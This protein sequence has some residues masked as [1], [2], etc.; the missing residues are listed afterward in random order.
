MRTKPLFELSSALEITPRPEWKQR[1]ITAITEDSRRAGPGSLFV[2]IRGTRADGNAFV[3]DA[4]ARGAGAVVTEEPIPLKVPCLTVPHARD[5]LARLSATFFDH[6]TRELRTIA[7]TGTNGKTTV[8]HLIAHLLG[9]DQTA[10]IGT[11]ANTATGLP[12]VTT[13]SPPMIQ[14]LARCAVEQGKK[15][16]VIEAS[17]VG[18]EQGR[19]KEVAFG[20][21]AFTNLTSDHL[22]LHH[23]V[24][25]YYEAK[26]ILFRT[27]KPTA[28]AVV[29]LDDPAGK[30]LLVETAARTFTVGRA[31]DADLRAQDIGCAW[32]ETAFVLHHKAAEA[33]V[34][35]PLTGMHNVSNV[36]VAAGVALCEGVPLQQIA[37]RLPSFRPVAGRLETLHNDTGVT[38]VVDFAHNTDALERTLETLRQFFP[39][40]ITVFGC[41]GDAD[42]EK[43]PA[44]GAT[45]Q[46][47]SDAVVVTTDNPKTEDPVAIFAEISAGFTGDRGSIQHIPDREQA[48][49]YAISL[50]HPGDVVLM[51]G[52]GHETHQI[53]DHHRMPYSDL[54]VLERFGFH[55]VKDETPIAKE[56][57][58]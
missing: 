13:P 44:M 43:R 47:L 16:L 56:A 23:S 28:W 22:D 31:P 48:I 37:Q 32:G 14:E 26:A 54:A 36:L 24:D 3:G 20:S 53:I 40:I 50:A 27:L 41:P 4:I 1:M 9:Q 5:A 38:A 19:L 39:R 55:P 8:C 33:G 17:S 7:V 12:D 10:I 30:R 45:A 18:L 2:A 57:T 35:V 51:A 15:V 11:V 6:P 29:N 21:A 49:R 46:R 52:K 42:R 34:R 25:A 58:P